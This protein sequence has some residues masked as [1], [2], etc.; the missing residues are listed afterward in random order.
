MSTDR[1]RI[2]GGVAIWMGA[3][4]LVVSLLL[5]GV[6]QSFENASWDWRVRSVA[7]SSSHDPLIKVITIDQASLEYVSK[8]MGLAWPWPRSI[9][10]PVL[11]FLDKAGAKGVA[12]DLLF[13]EPS[14][15]VGDDEAFAQSVGGSLP[16]VSAVALQRGDMEESPEAQSLFRARQ[17]EERTAIVSYVQGPDRPHYS[18]AALPVLPLLKASAGFGSV[19]SVADDDQIVRHTQPGAYL[20]DIPVLSLP[21]ALYA[22][23]HADTGST[24]DLLAKQDR[25]GDYLIRY[26]GPAA[27]YD[28]YSM[29]AILSS[30]IRLSE[31]KQAKVS[32]TEFKD[33]YVFIGGSAPG[34]L[35]LRAVPFEGAYPGVE[36]NATI[37][38]NVIHR[39]FLRH[40]PLP[41]AFAIALGALLLS[42][43]S[44]LFLKRGGLWPKLS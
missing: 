9:Y 21:F 37:L 28:T 11:E 7:S 15:E 41:Y 3:S 10:G 42:T 14:N 24:E 27:T 22:T 39:S 20:G 33:S 40:V 2:Q 26:F 32:P 17:M 44:G 5:L 18:A 1:K 8:E 43:L 31:G 19:T 30:A 25:R 36:V 38:D 29:S 16:V 12:F 35:D 34:L 6:F 13:T 23:A 4:V